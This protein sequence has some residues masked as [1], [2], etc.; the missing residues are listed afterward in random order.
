MVLCIL[1]LRHCN[2]ENGL[3]HLNDKCSLVDKQLCNIFPE[4]Y[5][6]SS[7]IKIDVLFIKFTNFHFM[8]S[9]CF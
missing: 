1:I 7:H 6:F 3:F 2:L 9:Y 5:N 4:T 8:Q